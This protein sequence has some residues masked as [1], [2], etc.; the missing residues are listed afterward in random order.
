MAP[1]SIAIIICSTRPG[2]INPFVARH[3]LDEMTRAGAGQ[4]T[5]NSISGAEHPKVKLELV[6]LAAQHLPLGEEPTVPARLPAG[7][8]TPHYGH[9]ST[10]AWSAVVRRHDAFVFVTPQ[11]NWS[12]PASLKNAL[13]LLYH[14]WAGKPAAIVTYG[15]RGGP[16]AA[17]H[18]RQIMAGLHM[19]PVA[20]PAVALKLVW[21]EKEP[22]LGE[23]QQQGTAEAKA[24][25]AM[26][27][28]WRTEGEDD[29]IRAMYTE[30]V[31]LL[32][33]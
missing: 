25:A 17:G 23:K 10:R 32:V 24:Q 31:K 15:S 33:P 28:L 16:K 11:Y 26:C 6:D 7:D 18:L 20:E 5:S 22:A 1:K 27:Q 9:A 19:G 12:V 3:V 30:L 21:P 8:P 2:R 29:K 13:D 14:E 4:E